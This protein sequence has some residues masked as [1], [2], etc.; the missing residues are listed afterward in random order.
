MKQVGKKCEKKM[1]M[2]TNRAIYNERTLC[3]LEVND[4]SIESGVG[5][6]KKC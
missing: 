6:E 2:G 1:G 3:L 5:F 4:L